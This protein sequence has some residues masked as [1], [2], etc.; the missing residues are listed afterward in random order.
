MAEEQYLA[1]WP[2]FQQRMHC[3]ETA[4]SPTGM[5]GTN[6]PNIAT[7]EFWAFFVTEVESSSIYAK[8]TVALSMEPVTKSSCSQHGGT[9]RQIPWKHLLSS[10][11]SYKLLCDQTLPLLSLVGTKQRWANIQPSAGTAMHAPGNG[12]QRLSSNP[13][14][15]L[16]LK[17]PWI[18]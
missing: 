7:F 9:V 15:S 16:G 8:V 10:R 14:I 13:W 3:W 2:S 17:R 11:V 1:M 4:L 12:A 5:N 6:L 18:V